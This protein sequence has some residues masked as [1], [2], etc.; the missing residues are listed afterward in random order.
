MESRLV[1]ERQK[2]RLVKL[3]L[4]WAALLLIAA[5][6]WS[7]RQA[8]DDWKFFAGLPLIMAI[9]FGM[10]WLAKRHRKTPHS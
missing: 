8:T 10:L 6:V 3:Q 9:C 4:G 1:T 5:I 2:L 7:I